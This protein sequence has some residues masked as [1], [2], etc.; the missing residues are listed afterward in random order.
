[1]Q[2]TSL[3]LPHLP[4]PSSLLVALL[5]NLSLKQTFHRRKKTDIA[6]QGNTLSV[7]LRENYVLTSNLTS[8]GTLRL[9]IIVREHHNLAFQKIWS[10][11]PH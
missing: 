3:L 7:E 9:S 1:M 8:E 6:D 5:R 10:P 11:V 4:V 2:K